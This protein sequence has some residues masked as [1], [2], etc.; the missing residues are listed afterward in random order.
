MHPDETYLPARPTDLALA[1]LPPMTSPECVRVLLADDHP[2]VR[3]GMARILDESE[4]IAIVGQAGCG[5]D[6]IR[7]VGELQPDVLL[8][9]FSLPDLDGTAVTL[10]LNEQYPDV[11]VL[12]LTMHEN[13]HYVLKALEA[14]AAGYLVKSDAPEE[15]IKAIGVV[16]R[17]AS[18]ITPRLAESV[19][20]H[21]RKPRGSRVGLAKLSAREF[22]LL[23]CLVR[24]LNLQQ[25][26]EHMIVSESTV[27]TYRH[28]LLTKLEVENNAQLI[29]FALDHG[30]DG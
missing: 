20:E 5:K 14:G 7:L 27:S 25:A 23:R 8:L 24:G 9:D 6:A 18:Y 2:V 11:R 17:G 16:H 26:A 1:D 12:I 28:R 3:E 21:L 22:E 13:I 30:I 4:G 15:L 29:R 10:K 19:A